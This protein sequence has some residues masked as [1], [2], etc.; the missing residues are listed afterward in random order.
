MRRGTARAKSVTRPIQ[1]QGLT[2]KAAMGSEATGLVSPA[3]PI[4]SLA[5]RVPY[6]NP[7]AYVH[8]DAV[9]IGDVTLGEDATVWPCAVL[10]GD[11]GAIRV[12]AR[13]SV[14]DGTVVH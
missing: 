5:D 14:Q 6:I 7:T 13:T 8:P 11:D 2:A 9:L 12:G 1:N 10:R 3:V 4:Y